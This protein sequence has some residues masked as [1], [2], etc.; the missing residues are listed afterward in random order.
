MKE[1]VWLQIRQMSK[2]AGEVLY[3]LIVVALSAWVVLF[4]PHGA[5]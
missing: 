1:Q 2:G 4:L 5:T 3:H